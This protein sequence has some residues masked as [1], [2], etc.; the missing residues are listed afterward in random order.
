MEN[1]VKEK[2]EQLISWLNDAYAMET[3]I[4]RNLEGQMQQTEDTPEVHDKIQEHL[5]Q[6][7][8]QAER[9]KACI[10]D[11]GGNISAIKSGL[12]NMMGAAKGAS[13]AMAED[14]LIKNAIAD[15]ATEYFEIASYTALIDAAEEL[16]EK[17]VAEVCRVIRNE[18]Q[19]MAKW[20]EKQLPTAV[21]QFMSTSRG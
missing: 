14:K 19:E 20:I 4:T 16:G 11:L 17:K 13:T 6:T 8:S 10:Q 5:E 7:K 9:V 12:A 3:D 15:Y 21:H 2:R 18:E 1:E